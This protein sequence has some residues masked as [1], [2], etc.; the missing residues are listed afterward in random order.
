MS[1]VRYLSFLFKCKKTADTLIRRRVLW[2]LIWSAF[3]LLPKKSM[4]DLYWVIKYWFLWF[5]LIWEK[6]MPKLSR[7]L[8]FQRYKHFISGILSILAEDKPDGF[9]FRKFCERTLYS[10]LSGTLFSVYW[11]VYVHWS[12]ANNIWNILQTLFVLWFSVPVYSYGHV[13]TAIFSGLGKLRQSKNHF[14]LDMLLLWTGSNL[15][16]NRKRKLYLERSTV[17][18]TKSDSN[19]FFVYNFK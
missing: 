4:L 9:F 19:I 17:V 18:P 12:F 11:H 5:C 14:Y 10:Y 15:E 13:K 6:Q 7:L 8:N 2:R 1:V 3:Y 16:S